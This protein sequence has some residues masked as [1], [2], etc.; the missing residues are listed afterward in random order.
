MTETLHFTRARLRRDASVR[1]LLPLLGLH[2]GLRPSV[3]HALV[4]SLF[5]DA[6]D[7]QRDFLYREA[8][9]GAVYI[10]SARP[11]QDRHALFDLDSK[12]Y[13]LD[14][15]VG[16][17]LAFS[18]RANPVIRRRVEGRKHSAKDDVVM[19]AVYRSDGRSSRRAIRED[20]IAE[21][22]AAWLRRVG[23]RAGFDPIGD[24]LNVDGYRQHRL[25][26]PRAKPVRFATL[27]FDGVLT[28]TEPDLFAASV[29]RGFGAARAFGC[30]LMLLRRA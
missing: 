30:G 17:R 16:D 27:D 20:A 29:A 24:R 22:G 19:R 5:S 10:L 28:I 1:S 25:P 12:P 23:G 11:P 18:L 15:Q 21:Q 7:R 3:S 13:A 14:L 8:G 9:D 4:W 6:T 26:R 2:E